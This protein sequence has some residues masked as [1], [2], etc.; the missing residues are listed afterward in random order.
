MLIDDQIASFQRDGAVLLKGMFA[1]YVENARTA[2]EENKAN[3]SWRE[4][5]Y[6]PD[7]GS[8][9]F[10]QDYCVWSQFDG[11]RSLVKDSPMA[12]CAAT[13]MQSKKARIFHDHILV[14]EP[15]NSIVTPW[16]QDQ[17][18][19]SVGHPVQANPF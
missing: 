4:R 5:T 18:Y 16:H 8:T 11:Y 2:I 10:F 7:D 12:E 1:D 19:Y 14:K 3:P 17:P 13:L 15:G 9:P 6:L